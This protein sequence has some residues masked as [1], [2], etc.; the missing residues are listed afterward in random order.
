LEES[1]LLLSQFFYAW[2]QPSR[3]AGGFSSMTNRL[4]FRERCESVAL[5][6]AVMKGF[7]G[8][9]ID[10]FPSLLASWSKTPGKS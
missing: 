7:R 1:T 6:T 10:L 4:D 8:S 2:I 9:V 3:P 5:G